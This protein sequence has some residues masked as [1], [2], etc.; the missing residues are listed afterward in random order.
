[1]RWWALV[2]GSSFVALARPAAAQPVDDASLVDPLDPSAI[3]GGG[4]VGACDWP[5]TVSLGGCTG[6]L[7][8]PE[9]V[10]YAAHCG[11]I[12]EVFLGDSVYEQGRTVYPE[13]CDVYP[14]GGP[15]YGNDW[16]VC[17]LSEAITDIPVTPPLMGCETEL[18]VEGQPVWIVGFGNT[19]DGNFGVKY[20]A[21]TV[22]HYIQ[23]DEAFVGGGGI[24]TCQGDSGGPVYIQLEDGSWRAF[25]IT[26]YGDGCG[27]G[28]W[29]SMMHT[30]MQW[31]E[32]TTG[33]DITP[34]HDA[35]GTW[36][37]GA[38]CTGFPMDPGTGAG[39]WPSCDAGALSSWSASCGEPFMATDDDAPPTVSI[40]SPSDGAELASDPGTGRAEILV[41]IAAAD[42]G[43]SGVKDVQLVI[44]GT[45]LANA[46]ENAPYQFSINLEPG[47]YTLSA[48]ATDLAG[49]SAES[50]AIDIGIDEAPPSGEG[51][52]VDDGGSA[53]QG[54]DGEGDESSDDGGDVRGSDP[55]DPALPPGFGLD[56][57]G[58]GCGCA[59]DR[60]RVRG[61]LLA[62]AF[63]LLRR[64]G[65]VRSRSA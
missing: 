60:R 49:N 45:A 59:T 6:T 41:D 21:Q 57:A 51:G 25:G 38:Q 46:D 58:E 50:A 40:T 35:D 23:N 52:Q 15:G 5:T 12:S 1:M 3:Y 20:E 17:K 31:F 8:H 61:W 16:A 65:L 9:V 34:C 54:D 62:C 22:F 42:P 63:F 36:N 44:D 32:E 55:T 56:G 30:G 48:I 24:D 10:I 53:E 13:F 4:P 2:L 39:S 29:Y 64:R 37:P 19:D 14:G 33:V 43:G 26:S 7:V 28:G 27:G 18:L 47:V 11:G